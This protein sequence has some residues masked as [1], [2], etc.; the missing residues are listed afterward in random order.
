MSGQIIPMRSIALAVPLLMWGIGIGVPTTPA[1]ADDCAAAPRSA[2]PA[3][4]HW[5]FQTDRTKRRKCWFLSPTGQA[6]QHRIARR[7]S[8]AKTAA[9]ASAAEKPATAATGAPTTTGAGGNTPSLT[10]QTAP[11]GSATAPDTGAAPSNPWA[12]APLASA[13]AQIAVQAAGAAPSSTIVWPDP[14]PFAPV[15]TQEPK[16]AQEPDSALGEARA[17]SVA[18][19]PARAPDDAKAAAGGGAPA[20]HA[21]VVEASSAARFVEI[22]L[23][24]AIG[25]TVA[26]LLYRL[27]MK[28]GARRAADY[29]PPLQVGLGRRAPQARVARRSAPQWMPHESERVLRDLPPSLIPA[30][31]DFRGRRSVR[32]DDE[33]QNAARGKDNVSRITDAVSGRETKL[34]QLI[35]DLEQLLQSRKEA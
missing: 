35:Q 22:L 15:R 27:V 7:P 17:E 4:S 26:G 25:L 2:A 13:S 29:R 12:A 30:A 34:T 3:G 23:V 19:P 16:L 6:G 10:A 9:R 5:Y 14:T 21:P 18:P 31:G 11:A 32:A 8:A 1:H 20:T 24:A 28:I 33:R